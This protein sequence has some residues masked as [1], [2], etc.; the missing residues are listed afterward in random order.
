VP[1]TAD[2]TEAVRLAERS[3]DRAVHADAETDVLD[4]V[5]LLAA[6]G[7]TPGHC[8]VAM[9][10]GGSNVVFLADAIIDELQLRY[11]Q[12]VG[13]V[14]W[15]GEQTVSTRL[16]L[17]DQASRDGS[18]VLAYHMAGIGYVESSAGSYALI[19]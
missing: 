17:L 12:W 7:H 5:R 13:A 16:H 15:S 6:P 2:A 10:G 19:P 11:P 8:V 4:G 3:R 14:E 18:V 1:S 9:N